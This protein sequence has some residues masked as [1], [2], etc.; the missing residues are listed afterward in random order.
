MYTPKFWMYLIIMYSQK[1]WTTSSSCAP[2]KFCAFSSS[3]THQS[4]VPSEDRTWCSYDT[5]YYSDYSLFLVPPPDLLYTPGAEANTIHEHFNLN[6]CAIV[7]PDFSGPG[8]TSRERD[9]HQAREAIIMLL[10]L[11]KAFIYYSVARW[12]SYHNVVGTNQ[13]LKQAGEAIIMLLVL[14]K[15]CSTL[16]KLS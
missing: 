16:G 1:F 11:I 15:V 14:I 12:G 9:L 7:T 8:D 13:G 3:C 4:S 5:G 10:V 2:V 6:P